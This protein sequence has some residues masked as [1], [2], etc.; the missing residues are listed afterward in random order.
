MVPLVSLSKKSSPNSRF[1]PMLLSRS[2]IVL[3]FTVRSVIHFEFFFVESVRSVSRFIFLHVDVQLFQH[4]LL[5][6][7]SFASLSKITWLYLCWSIS[8]LSILFL[9]CIC[10]FFCQSKPHCL[11][12]CSFIVSLEVKYSQSS[13]FVLLLQYWLFWFFYLSI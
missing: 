7:L 4:H 6:D 13:H 8:G 11:D 10:L 5:K 2:F 9:W 3:H 12:Y 1:S